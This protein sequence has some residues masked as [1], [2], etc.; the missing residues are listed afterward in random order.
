MLRYYMSCRPPAQVVTDALG[1]EQF[2]P[3]FLSSD[4]KSDMAGLLDHTV[5]RPG[6]LRT[7]FDGPVQFCLVQTLLGDCQS[8]G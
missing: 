1:P 3:T 7:L 5:I 8:K 4:Y 6:E 2:V